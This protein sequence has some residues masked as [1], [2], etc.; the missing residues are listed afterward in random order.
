MIITEA[1]VVQSI[2]LE[3]AEEALELGHLLLGTLLGL[4]HLLKQCAHLRAIG[5]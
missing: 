5:R 3:L 1:S 2:V 4:V